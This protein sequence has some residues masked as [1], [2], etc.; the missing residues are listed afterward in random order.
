M[1]HRTPPI[2]SSCNTNARGTWPHLVALSVLACL[3]TCVALPTQ[4][5]NI[6]LATQKRLTKPLEASPPSSASVAPAPTAST[7]AAPV[8]QRPSD[9]IV[10]VV[11]S[12]PIT[13]NEVYQETQRVLQQLAQQRST[14]PKM[15]ELAAQVLERLIN[16]KAQLQVA[17]ETGIRVDEATIDQSELGVAQQ[18]QVDVPT[19]RRRLAQDG[20]SSSQ[21]RD[22]LRDQMLLSRIREREVDA[23]VR[24]SDAEVEQYLR[25][26]QTNTDPA[27]QNINIAQILV[28]VPD[29][30]TPEQL[31]ALQAKADAV[32]MR[33]QAGEDFTRLVSELSDA[34]DR[35]K[36]GQLGLRSAGR[37]PPLFVEATQGLATGGIS[38]VIRSG[39]GFHVLKVIE[40]QAAGLP[41][42]TVIQNRSRHILLR[43]GPQLS[44]AAARAK[45]LDFKQ[46]IATGKTDFATLARENSQDGSAAQGGDLG[47]ASPGQF[48]PEFENVLNALTPGQISEPLLSRFGLHLIQLNERRTSAVSARDQRE[49]VR[50]MLRDKKLDEAYLTWAQ[51]VRGRAYVEMREPPQ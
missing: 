3:A 18:N 9:F 32:L 13:N 35:A 17:R 41:P 31:A 50:A 30:A 21:F 1:T 23:R 11:N 26:Q 38:A 24:V 45:L 51:D 47:W 43:P 37:Y 15:S 29:N 12:E 22:Q 48:V 39:A 19:L 5:Q 14:Q 46:R 4:A 27:K 33:A 34:T 40:R 20:I 7:P 10:A 6:K 16:D 2:T 28:A 44:E 36:G 25:E 8:A 42:V 49:A